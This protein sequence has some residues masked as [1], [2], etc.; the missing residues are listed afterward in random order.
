M[1]RYFA[2]AV[3]IREKS[4]LEEFHASALVRAKTSR[5]PLVP[6]ELAQLNSTL[7]RCNL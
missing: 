2:Y 1:Y 3:S 4:R 5:F 7:P 6:R